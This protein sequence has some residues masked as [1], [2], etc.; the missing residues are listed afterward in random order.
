MDLLCTAV[1]LVASQQEINTPGINIGSYSIQKDFVVNLGSYNRHEWYTS[2][3]G[4][5]SETGHLSL[6]M[7]W[8]QWWS[9]GV[10]VERACYT[11]LNKRH[12]N[13]VLILWSPPLESFCCNGTIKASSFVEFH[14]CNCLGCFLTSRGINADMKIFISL[15]RY[16]W[17][18][19]TTVVVEQWTESL[20]T[21]Q[22][23]L[24]HSQD[25]Y[26]LSF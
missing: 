14:S 21:P 22:V 2:V 11:L 9:I 12:E 16:F 4:Q 3:V 26:R 8:W 17:R 6:A 25:V 23:D 24:V 18:S 20:S 1:S 19:Q 5:S 13:M 10:V 15:W 7:G